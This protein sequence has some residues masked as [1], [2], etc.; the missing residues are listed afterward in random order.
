[1]KL[2][3]PILLFAAHVAVAQASDLTWTPATDE[4]SLSVAMPDLAKRVMAD[5]QEAD[6]DQ[7]LNTLFRLQ[8]VAGEWDNALTS[9][10]A[11]RDLRR[12]RDATVD[13]LFVQ[14][15]ILLIARRKHAQIAKIKAAIQP[16]DRIWLSRTK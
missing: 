3:L 15:E 9:I 11:L 13:T 12:P 8:I 16:N 1:M 4:A 2:F 10:R 7:Y 5:Y 14:Y 6:R